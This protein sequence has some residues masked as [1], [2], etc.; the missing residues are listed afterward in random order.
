[1]TT[2]NRDA[3][4][5]LTF[6]VSLWVSPGKPQS[7]NQSAHYI[8][9]L[10]TRHQ[11]KKE[12]WR[13]K[14]F[15]I[16]IHGRQFELSPLGKRTHILGYVWSWTLSSDYTLTCLCE[17]NY[18]D[19]LKSWQIQVAGDNILTFKYELVSL[20]WDI[21]LIDLLQSLTNGW[22]STCSTCFQAAWRSC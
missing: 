4:S 11:K 17:H 6:L 8:K 5:L 20:N 2:Q 1:M 10:E 7:Q 12:N 13:N 22:L 14:K 9:D 15:S 3:C 19:T 16:H 18:I 21:L